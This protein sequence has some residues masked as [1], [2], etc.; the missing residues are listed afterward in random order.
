[1]MEQWWKKE[2]V[3]D[4]VNLVL[5]AWLFLTPWIFGFASETA[6][7]WTAWL[8]GTAIAAVAIA[9]LAAFA[10]WEEWVSL[11]LGVWVVVSAWVVGFAAHATATWVNVLTGIAVAVVAGLRLWFMHRTPPRVTA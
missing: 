7:G 10:E 4:V 11:V 6:A 1:M 9:A 3:S 5:G 8:S 2:A